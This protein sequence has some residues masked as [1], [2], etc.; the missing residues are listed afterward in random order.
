MAYVG[1]RATG[2][3]LMAL[4]SAL[5]A[6]AQSAQSAQPAT[7]APAREARA[8]GSYGTGTIRGRVVDAATGRGLPR[9]ALELNGGQPAG[10]AGETTDEDGAFEFRGLPPGRYSIQATKATYETG[11]L[12][13]SRRGRQPRRLELASGATLDKLTIALY[14]ASA[15]VGR[16]IDQFGEPAA[17]VQV[18]IRKFPGAGGGAPRA[19][20][21][22]MTRTNDI[23]EFRL[24]PA[25]PGR[26][27]LIAE[28]AIEPFR[29]GLPLRQS[30]FAAWPQAPS[31]DQAQALVV[32]RGEDIRDIE[33][34]LFP[35]KSSPVSGVILGLDGAPATT[36]SIQISH[37]FPGD[38][39]SSGGQSTSTQ[40]G[41]FELRLPP[42][43]YDLGGMVHGQASLG[44]NR[45][46][47]L[48]SAVTRVTVDG[49]PVQGLTLQL[50]PPRT[51]S[52]RVVFVPSGAAPRTP[53][54]TAVRLT[55]HSRAPMGGSWTVSVQPDFTF[56]MKVIGD[57]LQ[58]AT[59]AQGWYMRSILQGT[60]DV[61]I[62]GIRFGD[63]SSVSDVVISFTDR[64]TK[65]SA[66]VADAKGNAADE[67]LVAVFPVDKARR[68]RSRNF[69]QRYFVCRE[70]GPTAD[71]SPIRLDGLLPGDYFVIALTPDDYDASG[72]PDSYDALEPLA[73]RFTLGEGEVRTLSLTI[74][75]VPR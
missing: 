24:A 22:Y 28:T 27:L 8:D 11:Y 47:A 21:M 33:L 7:N 15:I 26:Y 55:L 37:V 52:G 70:A 51:V 74:V 75:D 25:L 34:R 60:D 43:T 19:S 45:P 30:G 2:V 72:M 5:D 29:R 65:L 38:E 40:N 61:T 10:S 39:E 68:P 42:G 41:R 63:R 20:G 64:P 67:F 31:I 54:P 3:L 66:T 73:Q 59:G 46:D 18:T 9:V 6:F 62:D 44:A 1:K 50:M 32:E 36:S 53:D 17:H 57:R 58:V 14:R 35:T 23:G 4:V 16:V 56:S 49:E 12:P 13:E 71:G 48:A 69:G